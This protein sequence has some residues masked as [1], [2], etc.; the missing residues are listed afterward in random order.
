MVI[1]PLSWRDCGCWC[2]S[3]NSS[4]C[5]T[6]SRSMS[7]HH[8]LWDRMSHTLSRCVRRVSLYPRNLVTARTTTYSKTSSRFKLTQCRTSINLIIL[9]Y[10]CFSCSTRSSRR[11]PIYSTNLYWHSV[12][13]TTKTMWFRLSSWCCRLLSNKLHRPYSRSTSTSNNSKSMWRSEKKTSSNL[14]HNLN[15]NTLC[16]VVHNY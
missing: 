8:Q 11:T 4:A 5:E 15:R 13:P 16:Q 1:Y 3:F 6:T 9:S 2:I 10:S 7:S 14:N 12:P